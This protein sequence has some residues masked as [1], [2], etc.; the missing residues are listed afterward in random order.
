MSNTIASA[1]QVR[2]LATLALQAGVVPS[3][4][5]VNTPAITTAQFTALKAQFTSQVQQA[6]F[7]FQSAP[8]APHQLALLRAI[9]YVSG[10]RFPSAPATRLQAHNW[11]QAWFRNSANNG[12]VVGVVAAMQPTLSAIPA[13]TNLSGSS[14]KQ[15]RQLCK[16][17]GITGYSAL[18]KAGLIAALQAA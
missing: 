11:L 2:Y 12:H 15:L 17:A 9:M 18:S 16:L 5:G 14:V 13:S 4:A 8:P 7:G 6:V 1:A 10:Q 3:V